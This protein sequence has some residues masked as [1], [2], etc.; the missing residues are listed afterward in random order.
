MT[1]RELYDFTTE[2]LDGVELNLTL[3]DVFLNVAQRY[4]EGRRLWA[5]LRKEDASQ[6]ISAS[7]TFET[8][9]NLPSDFRSFYG[10]SPIVLVD[11]YGNKQAELKEI[12]LQQKFDYRGRLDR[13]YCDYRQN[14]FFIC[15]S[16][17]Q[18]LTI[19]L[20]Y[21]Y[22]PALI[23]GDDSNE[24]VFPADYHQILGLSV[25]VYYKKGVDY[26]IV[27]NVQADNN[28][29][30]AGQI[31]HQMSEWDSVLDNSMLQGQDFF[32]TE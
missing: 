26:D 5:I 20:F 25:A 9:K 8:A 6:T 19:R 29:A 31:Y 15:G 17:A 12:P 18:S 24:W 23:S 30:L 1:K 4:W 7:N 22:K 14:Q 28:A 27:N 13:F 32:E 21:I 3:F 11:N 16:P 10:L 2:L